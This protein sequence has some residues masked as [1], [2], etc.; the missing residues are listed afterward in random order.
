MPTHPNEG[1][2]APRVSDHAAVTNALRNLVKAADAFKPAPKP[3]LDAVTDALSV[4]ATRDPEVP[5]LANR[6][7]YRNLLT[8]AIETSAVSYWLACHQ[9]LR[10]AA[11]DVIRIVKPCAADEEKKIW[12]DVDEL[13]IQRGMQRIRDGLV[14]V[15]KDLFAMVAHGY[16][17]PDDADI[18][19]EGVDVILQ[20][21]MFGKLVYG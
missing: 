20:A 6:Q 13:T 5:V 11:G 2:P 14:D 3:V 17:F 21:G 9:V 7:M 15:N 10:D 1:G 16:V 4:L 19:A 8:D 12:A 18:D